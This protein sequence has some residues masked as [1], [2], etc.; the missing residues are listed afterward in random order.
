MW[1]GQS[2]R[3]CRLSWCSKPQCESKGHCWQRLVLF[4]EPWALHLGCQGGE[5]V[6]L[7]PWAG[8]LGPAACLTPFPPLPPVEAA[9]APLTPASLPSLP[10]FPSEGSLSGQLTP[11]LC[12]SCP[13]TPRISS[14]GGASGTWLQEYLVLSLLGEFFHYGV[15]GTRKKW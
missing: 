13:Q 14:P 2:S 5:Q 3:L 4:Q 7:Q 12:L 11:A 15:D 10:Q 9:W 1:S 6:C 8:L